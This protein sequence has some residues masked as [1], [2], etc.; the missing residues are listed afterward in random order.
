MTVSSKWV[1]FAVALTIA[2]VPGA[3]GLI[4]AVA[5][6]LDAASTAALGQTQVLLQTPAERE[7]VVNQTAAAQTADAEAK[8]LA[9][10]PAN[11]EDIYKISSDIFADLVK[12]ANGDPQKMQQMLID[13]KNDPKGFYERLSEKNR[14]SIHEISGKISDSPAIVKPA[15]NPSE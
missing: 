6:E 4:M 12:Q 14:R 7:K 1:L 9:G 10:N 8:A 2:I 5:G 15:T 3:S 11:T 13:A